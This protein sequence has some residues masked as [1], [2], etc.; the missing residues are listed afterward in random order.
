MKTIHD[1]LVLR[2]WLIALLE[3][4]EVEEDPERRRALLTIV[5]AGGGFSGVETVGMERGGARSRARRLPDRDGRTSAPDFSRAGRIVRRPS[6]TGPD[7]LAADN[8]VEG[9]RGGGRRPVEPGAE[10]AGHQRPGHS[11]N[12]GRS[13]T[14]SERDG[15]SEL[16][17]RE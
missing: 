15:L 11:H 13:S 16:R 2:N 4:A 1:A 5:V 3:R 17:D 6:S 10:R 12:R 7:D 8:R 14:R 9:R